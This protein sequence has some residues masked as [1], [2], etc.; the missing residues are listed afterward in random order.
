MQPINFD[1]FP[2]MNALNKGGS[3]EQPLFISNMDI[4]EDKK[5]IARSGY[6]KILSINKP[7]SIYSFDN[8]LLFVSDSK[9]YLYG[10]PLTELL[11]FNNNKQIYYSVI[12]DSI[13]IGNSFD[14]YRLDASSLSVIGGIWKADY[15]TYYQG[16]LLG[17]NGNKLIFSIPTDFSFLDSINYL[18]MPSNI[19]MIAVS[20]SIG[21]VSPEVLYIGTANRTVLI[22]G[23]IVSPEYT[24]YNSGVVDNTLVYVKEKGVDTPV[25]ASSKGV[26]MGTIN[27]LIVLD[28]NNLRAT[29]DTSKK[30]S[31]FYDL[32]KDSIGII[33]DKRLQT[34]SFSDNMIVTIRRKNKLL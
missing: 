4:T 16:R 30:G 13:Y 29:F 14:A 9:L 1:S 11:T 21:S 27:G 22:N 20:K 28:S 6:T 26:T 31:S 8:K 23:N 34:T 19:Q 3:F 12:G 33:A 10:N 5:L 2:G 7:H 17:S 32:K 18:T 25:W 24:Y 15:Y